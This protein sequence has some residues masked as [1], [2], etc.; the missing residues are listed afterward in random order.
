MTLQTYT[1]LLGA[2][3]GFVAESAVDG[4]SPVVADSDVSVFSVINPFPKNRNLHH[5]SHVVRS[6]WAVHLNHYG[7]GRIDARMRL[8]YSADRPVRKVCDLRRMTACDGDVSFGS[9]LSHLTRWLDIRG[10]REISI[11][12][13][14][15]RAVPPIFDIDAVPDPCSVRFLSKQFSKMIEYK[16]RHVSIVPDRRPRPSSWTVVPNRRP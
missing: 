16:F 5:V 9:F 13:L 8:T 15:Q 10:A 11:P 6:E 7:L 1:Q 3:E 14:R 12:Q 2:L 4:F